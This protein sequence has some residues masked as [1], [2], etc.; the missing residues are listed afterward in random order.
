MKLRK[1]IHYR[2]TSAQRNSL[3]HIK[4]Q[5]IYVERKKTIAP[6]GIYSCTKEVCRGENIHCRQVQVGHQQQI[7]RDKL[8]KSFTTTL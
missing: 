1:M 5:Q 4:D 7:I 2:M 6:L 8:D 3:H